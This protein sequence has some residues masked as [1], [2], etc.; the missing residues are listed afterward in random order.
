MKN[1]NRKGILAFLL[2]N[3][4]SAFANAQDS[5]DIKKLED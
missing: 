3:L 4:I 5:V 2:I 1:L